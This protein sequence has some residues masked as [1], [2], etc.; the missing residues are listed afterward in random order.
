MRLSIL[1]SFSSLLG[2]RW[3]SGL[4]LFFV[5]V[6]VVIFVVGRW[7]RCVREVSGGVWPIRSV[8]CY[9]VSGFEF[10]GWSGERGCKGGL[11]PHVF[12]FEVLTFIDRGLF[13]RSKIDLRKREVE[14]KAEREDIISWFKNLLWS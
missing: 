5:V 9:R 7:D 4:S 3:L 11:S 6:V 8:R 2:G 12:R 13:E 10:Y 1:L 14:R